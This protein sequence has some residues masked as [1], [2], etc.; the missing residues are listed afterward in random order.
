MI[1]CR[2]ESVHFFGFTL[3]IKIA[4]KPFIIGS[5][6]PEGLNYESFVGKG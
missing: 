3:K 4:Q 1:T 6:G 5:S 2:T